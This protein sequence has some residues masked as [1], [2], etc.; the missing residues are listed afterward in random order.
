MLVL[1]GQNFP[2]WISHVLFYWAASQLFC[3][4]IFPTRN[5]NGEMRER[6]CERIQ[7]AFYV[8]VPS[9]SRMNASFPRKFRTP[10]IHF[11]LIHK[12][13]KLNHSWEGE[14]TW[15]RSKFRVKIS[16]L[17][18]QEAEM[19]TFFCELTAPSMLLFFGPSPPYASCLDLNDLLPL[20]LSCRKSLSQHKRDMWRS[21][22]WAVVHLLAGPFYS[23][24]LMIQK[25]AIDS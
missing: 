21:T 24:P 2:Q 1:I 9:S 18:Q 4:H 6:E 16:F 8:S 5:P 25:D 19:P 3:T 14:R 10:N 23:S 13:F 12:I 11:H 17:S 7:S 22:P 15:E 20:S